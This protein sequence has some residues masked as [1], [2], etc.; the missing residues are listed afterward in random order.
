MPCF[1]LYLKL[2]YPTVPLQGRRQQGCDSDVLV[3]TLQIDQLP[4]VENAP[5]RLI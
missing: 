1:L 3:T 4:L 5:V 2:M